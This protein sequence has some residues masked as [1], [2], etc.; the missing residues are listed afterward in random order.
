MLE[1]IRR[2]LGPLA[3]FLFA[4]VAPPL[5]A[6]DAIPGMQA[7]DGQYKDYFANGGQESGNG[8]SPWAAQFWAG[9]NGAQ[10]ANKYCDLCAYCPD[11]KRCG[12]AFKYD[13][14]NP[15]NTG[16]VWNQQLQT[17]VAI[18]SWDSCWVSKQCYDC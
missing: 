17:Y 14:K 3:F 8:D 18:F 9:H 1:R 12:S 10:K 2:T 13:W 15:H 16:G 6:S 11:G 7:C 4:L 5:S